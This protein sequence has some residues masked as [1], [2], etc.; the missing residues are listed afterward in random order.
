MSNG[1][2]C[3]FWLHMSIFMDVSCP[4]KRNYM[5]SF[6]QVQSAF[7]PASGL[8]ARS[9]VWSRLTEEHFARGRALMPHQIFLSHL[10]SRISLLLLSKYFSH[11]SSR[12][13]NGPLILWP[14]QA[15]PHEEHFSCSTSCPVIVRLRIGG[16]GGVTMFR[17]CMKPAVIAISIY[18]WVVNYEL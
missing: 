14:K 1:H 5:L 17:D 11:F 15:F 13:S 3:H 10:S 12:I 9:T 6:F 16:R 18:E 8:F 7:L 2:L 4:V